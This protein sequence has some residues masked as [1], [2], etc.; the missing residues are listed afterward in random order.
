MISEMAASIVCFIKFVAALATRLC[1]LASE[2][3]RLQTIINESVGQQL[4][5]TKV[6]NKCNTHNV[7]QAQNEHVGIFTQ[8]NIPTTVPLN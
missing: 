8:V 1:W 7:G 6:R 2:C 4:Q 5:R 3:D